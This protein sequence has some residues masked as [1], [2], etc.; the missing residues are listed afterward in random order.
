MFTFYSVPHVHPD[1]CSF[2]RE[3]SAPESEALR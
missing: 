3:S 1:K 2:S